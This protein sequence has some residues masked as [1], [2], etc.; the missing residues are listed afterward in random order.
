M[1][2]YSEILVVNYVGSEWAMSNE[3][4]STL[5]WFSDTPKPTQAELDALIPNTADEVAK[6]NCKSEA[7]SILSQTDWTSIP[8]V[9]SSTA[10]N[11]YLVNQAAFIAYR[12]QI[13]ALAVNPVTNPIWPTPPTEQW[14][15]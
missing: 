12:S 4:Y 13:R 15:S 9:G 11:P 2:N 1:I 8:D 7:T 6:Q 10:S 3:D 14:S 5:Q